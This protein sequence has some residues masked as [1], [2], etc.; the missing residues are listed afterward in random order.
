MQALRLPARAKSLDAF[1]T[2]A[3]DALRQ[4]GLEP[5]ALGRVEL[6]L[7]ELLTNIFRHAYGGGPGDVELACS[8]DGGAFCLKLT[9]WGPPFNPLTQP[10]PDTSAPL[11]SR[12]IGGLGIHL[13]RHASDSLD[14]RREGDRNVVTVCVRPPR[15]AGEKPSKEE[16]PR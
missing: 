10:A 2:F 16:G 14:Y 9:D 6:V 13:V 7:E 8:A 5:S 3:A 11:D 12:P 15:P 4:S 1:R